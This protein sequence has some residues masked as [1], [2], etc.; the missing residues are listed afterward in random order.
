MKKIYLVLAIILISVFS[1]VRSDEQFNIRKA[2]WGMTSDE[3]IKSENSVLWINR[4]AVEIP[5]GYLIL[6]ASTEYK[7]GFY[8]ILSYVLKNNHLV[9]ASY[10]FYPTKMLREDYTKEMYIDD[11]KQIQEY[12]EKQ[13]GKPDKVIKDY[14]CIWNTDRTAIIH[15]IKEQFDSASHGIIYYDIKVWKQMDEKTVLLNQ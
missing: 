3:V 15:L 6:S 4:R 11:F 10:W 12:L 5:S 1:V 2:Q 13:Y 8:S 14:Q 9:S 7:K